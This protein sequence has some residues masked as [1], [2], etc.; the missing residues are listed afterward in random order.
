[1]KTSCSNNGLKKKT[2]RNEEKQDCLQDSRKFVPSHNE[3]VTCIS[4]ILIF[5]KVVQRFFLREN[6]SND[7]LCFFSQI[8]ETPLLS[9]HTPI[10]PVRVVVPKMAKQFLALSVLQAKTKLTRGFTHSFLLHFRTFPSNN[11]HEAIADKINPPSPEK[12]S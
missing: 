12:I 2:M 1:M 3:H 11:T 8:C 7:K 4:I 6:H 5:L 9:F 10:Y